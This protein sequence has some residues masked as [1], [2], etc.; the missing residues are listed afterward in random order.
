MDVKVNDQ[1]WAALSQDEQARIAGIVTG[2]FKGARIVPDPATARSAAPAGAA[3]PAGFIPKPICIAACNV[4]QA[5]A[6]A[7][8][9]ALGNPIAIAACVAAAQAAGDACRKA[10]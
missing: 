9:A 4:A 8:C 2:F 5:A 6:S 10:C 1:E 7:A 3:A